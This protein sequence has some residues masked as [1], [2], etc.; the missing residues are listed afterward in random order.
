MQ[1]KVVD[2]VG[3]LLN[4]NHAS[5]LKAAVT[6]GEQARGCVPIVFFDENTYY[7]CLLILDCL[8]QF[9]LNLLVVKFLFV[10]RHCSVHLVFYR[11]I[12]S[13]SKI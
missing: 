11:G 3:Q 12:F 13:M 6:T 1:Q 4:P 9:G 10:D 5:L 8:S 2:D 7:S